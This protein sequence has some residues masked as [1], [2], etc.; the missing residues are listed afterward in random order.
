MTSLTEKN[1][2]FHIFLSPV[3]NQ[4]KVK[5]D[6]NLILSCMQYNTGVYQHYPISPLVKSNLKL[7]Q[8]LKKTTCC[9]VYNHFLR[10]SYYYMARCS[11]AR[12]ME[13]SDWLFLVGILQYGPLS[14]PWKRSVTV[15]FCT[16]KKFKLSET[17]KV[18]QKGNLTF[19]SQEYNCSKR[20]LFLH[21]KGYHS[22][23][24]DGKRRL[25]TLIHPAKRAIAQRND[26]I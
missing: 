24:N 23:F 14:W 12:W 15:S 11:Q 9:A 6:S 13:H 1:Q 21:V 10:D 18:P 4:E 16:P 5:E 20:S 17:T 8:R 26:A 22:K 25:R 7:F 3:R 19:S 2:I